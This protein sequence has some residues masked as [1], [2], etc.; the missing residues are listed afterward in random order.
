M[1]LR[2]SLNMFISFSIHWNQSWSW[3]CSFSR[4][5][6]LLHMSHGR[7][8]G[9]LLLLLFGS[10]SKAVFKNA[11]DAVFLLLLLVIFDGKW[12]FSSILERLEYQHRKPYT[13]SYFPRHECVLNCLSM[14]EVFSIQI[15]KQKKTECMSCML[16]M[17]EWINR[18][19]TSRVWISTK[20]QHQQQ[21]R[22]MTRYSNYK[23]KK[24]NGIKKNCEWVRERDRINP[25][26]TQCVLCAWACLLFAVHP[27]QFIYL[28]LILLHILNNTNTSSA[29][30]LT[31]SPSPSTPFTIRAAQFEIQ[32]LFFVQFHL[33]ISVLCFIAHLI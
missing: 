6:V 31:L 22:A 10:A 24:S 8:I 4:W 15:Q 12:V 30:N 18:A 1:N 26:A 14:R 33:S 17:N 16:C 21:T 28:L 29:M 20:E 5:S 11:T 9:S 19:T 23:I 3:N 7:Q 2:S 27:H 13:F 32:S 25:N